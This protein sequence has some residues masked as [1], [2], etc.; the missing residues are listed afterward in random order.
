[1]IDLAVKNVYLRTIN[2]GFLERIRIGIVFDLFV[3]IFHG[4]RNWVKTCRTAFLTSD[5]REMAFT[6]HCTRTVL[7]EL[8]SYLQAKLAQFHFLKS[9]IVQFR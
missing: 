7:Q 1:M 4:T 9:T 2:L 8:Q 6:Q 5:S 3:Y